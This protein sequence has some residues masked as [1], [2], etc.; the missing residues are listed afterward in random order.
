MK[1]HSA[2]AVLIAVS[3]IAMASMLDPACARGAPPD[4]QNY[5]TYAAYVEGYVMDAAS[6][7][8]LPGVTVQIGETSMETNITGY[9]SIDG[10]SSGDH[11]VKASFSGYKSFNGTLSVTD[12]ENAVIIRMEPAISKSSPSC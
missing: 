6:G 9:F 1:K 7:A 5:A 2:I 8:G 12:G 11:S 3:V 4:E 10:L